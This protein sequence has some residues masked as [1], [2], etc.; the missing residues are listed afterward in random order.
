MTIEEAI[1]E[2]E[3][4]KENNP[5]V[6]IKKRLDGLIMDLDRFFVKPN[7]IDE[8]MAEKI[9]Y[10]TSDINNVNYD[11]VAQLHESF[12]LLKRQIECKN[13]L[14][15]NKGKI[16]G[17]TAQWITTSVQGVLGII[18]TV[19]VVLFALKIIPNVFGKLG[20]DGNSDALYYVIGTITQQAAAL[21]LAIIIGLINK[22]RMKK[23]YEQSE[24]SFEELLAIKYQSQPA[25][26]KFLLPVYGHHNAIGKDSKVID[27]STYGKKCRKDKVPHHNGYG[28]GSE[29]IDRSI[30]L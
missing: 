9:K 14:E 17:E 30:H 26:L 12:M 23:K 1:K 13:K 6:K 15:K 2:L 22:K 10:G 24:F 27:E 20:E 11:W 3:I 16:D 28:D 18:S 29:V 4:I 21:V 5:N 25:K 7:E 8:I 19:L